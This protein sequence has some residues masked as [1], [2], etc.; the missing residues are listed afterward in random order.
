MKNFW[1]LVVS[2][3]CTV[4]FGQ[5]LTPMP[6]PISTP[7]VTAQITPIQ[8]LGQS[9]RFCAEIKAELDAADFAA[10]AA[11]QQVAACQADYNAAVQGSVQAAADFAESGYMNP[12]C[13][14]RMNYWAGQ[15]AYCAMRL[16]NAQSVLNYALAELTR[17]E[18]EYA[19][20]GC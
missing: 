11:Q 18:F 3:L 12:L 17:L 7:V 19:G 10:G 9:L 15:I 6:D 2:A 8:Q 1:F 5:G 13:I 4:C 16:S 14:I 20:K